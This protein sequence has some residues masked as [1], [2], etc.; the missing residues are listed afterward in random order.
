MSR[1]GSSTRTRTPTDSGSDVSPSSSRSGS[2]GEGPYVDPRAK[3]ARCIRQVA[4][5]SKIIG[6]DLLDK[7]VF[8]P[9]FLALRLPIASPKLEKLFA[10]IKHLDEMDMVASGRHFK[11]M[12]FSDVPSPA[13][14]VKAV[15]SAFIAKGFTPA[16]VQHSKGFQILGDAE[17]A[18]T[19]GNNFGVLMSKPLFG[20]PLSTPFKKKLLETYNARP[21]NEKGA[22]IRFIILDQGF[23]E[24][25]DLFD[26][27]YVH[28]MEPL[29]NPADEKQAI[30][31]G[32]RFCGQKGLEFSPR[33]GWPLFVFRYDS[34]LPEGVLM[35]AFHL[36]YSNIDIRKVVLA[37]ELERIAAATAVDH[38]LTAPVHS[39]K[40]PPPPALMVASGGAK[41]RSH[42]SDYVSALS[43]IPPPKRLSHDR[44]AKYISTN[45]K[46]FKY[47]TAKLE[48]RCMDGGAAYSIVDFTPSQNF[49]RH[50]FTPANPYKGMLLYH[51]VG[52]GKTCTAIATATSS[53]E[54]EGYN[55]M[56]VTRH[57]LKSDIFKNMF[58]Q[59]CSIVFQKALA[60]GTMK[61]PT[62][63]TGLMGHL[64]DRWVQPMSYK[65]F[66]N[67]LLKK[68]RFYTEMVRRNGAADPLKKTLLIIDEAHK[69][70]TAS[71]PA[72]EKPN[73]AI[74]E[75]MIKNSYEESGMDSVR[76]LA[77]TATPFTEDPMEMIKIL[78][79]MREDGDEMPA[80]F[81]DFATKYLDA[82]GKFTVR[83]SS[84]FTEDTAG[85]ISYLNRSSDAR[86]FA[87][88]VI[89]NI[90]V[91]M[92]EAPPEPPEG[93]KAP[94][95]ADGLKSR[96]A[97][98]KDAFKAAKN[99]KRLLIKD[100]KADGR[101]DYKVLVE[102]AREGVAKCKTD[103]DALIAETKAVLAADK[104]ACVD[105]KLKGAAAKLCNSQATLK[106]KAATAELKER[107]KAEC[108]FGP[109]QRGIVKGEHATT[110]KAAL[111]EVEA[112]FAESQA[113]YLEAKATYDALNTEKKANSVMISTHKAPM[114]ELR[115]EYKGLQRK[116]NRAREGIKAIRKK[117]AKREA[118]KKLREGMVVPFNEA[119]AKYASVSNVVKAMR[120]KNKIIRIKQGAATLGDISQVTAM[121]RDCFGEKKSK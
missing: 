17:L 49:I 110:L 1:S 82:G 10:Q 115:M 33:Y 32:T 65:Q 46:E 6:P 18:K 109:T 11:H 35:S 79:L 97:D 94:L 21:D 7:A 74:L 37:A 9:E 117:V 58:K 16:F 70:Y 72:S 57:T 96:L 63:M 28:L 95:P 85:Y 106:S 31:R 83:G 15:A 30:G 56:W 20:R 67:M 88:P 108:V 27:K 19:A 73:T 120:T 53:F 39:F 47:P 43:A 50:Y 62:K 24:G 69:L 44:L 80:E 66:S 107:K 112:K 105:L 60:A 41:S 42:S 54:P 12:I 103:I 92:S 55:I 116:I 90:V 23:K 3:K 13:Y 5:F 26:I 118:Q 99:D 101:G 75:E 51:S 22:N 89:Q 40:V 45:F 98:M 77:M 76:V 68:N 34:R 104:A 38:D 29:V 2:E 8:D 102:A 81:D 4:A 111:E 64:S 71:G 121:N 93:E 25:I 14:G 84:A 36:S 52:T 59:V 113:G 114:M 61:M 78:N 48:N 87:Y 91:P 100:T 86:N 119:K